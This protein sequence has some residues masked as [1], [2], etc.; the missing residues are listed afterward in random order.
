MKAHMLDNDLVVDYVLPG[1]DGCSVDSGTR[2]TSNSG[3]L[4]E[5][6]SVLAD[7]TGNDAWR[8]QYVLTSY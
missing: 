3:S 5:G 6:F 8:N 4:I 7:V 1:P 2:Q